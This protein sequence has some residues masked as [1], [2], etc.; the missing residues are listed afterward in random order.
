MCVEYIVYRYSMQR[1]SAAQSAEYKE[2]VKKGQ[3]RVFIN[4]FWKL[5]SYMYI[6]ILVNWCDDIHY[7]LRM[8]ITN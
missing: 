5:F 1:L 6:N 8:R 3:S 2:T 7:C 4:V